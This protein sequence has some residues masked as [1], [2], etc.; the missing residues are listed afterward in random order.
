[1]TIRKPVIRKA[2]ACF[3]L[4]LTASDILLPTAAKALTSGPKQPEMTQFQ[5]AGMS[6]MVDLFSGDFKYNIPLLDVDGYPVN[7]NYAQGI[8]MDDEA[9]W[10]GLGWNLNV[11]TLN[12]QLR[13]VPDDHNGDKVE[14]VTHMKPKVTTGGSFR[15]RVEVAG[16]NMV[17]VGGSLSL[18]VFYDNYT[19]YGAEFGVGANAGLSL[20]GK[21]AGSMTMGL[22]ADINSNTTSGVS[23]TLGASL[24]YYMN[25]DNTGLSTANSLSVGYN[26]REG[27][28]DLT[29]GTSY[30]LATKDEKGR[31]SSFSHNFGSASISLNTPAFY[32]AAEIP[33]R[34]TAKTFTMDVGGAAYL[35]SV[36]VGMTGYKTVR[37]L[38]SNSQAN[39]AY[40]SMYAHNGKNNPQAL[41]DFT[42]EKDNIVVKDMN[43]IG[44]PVAMPD[45]WNYSSQAGGGQF[46]LYNGGSGVFFNNR[47]QDVSDNKTLGTDY[48]WGAYFHGGVTLFNQA[49]YDRSQK[50]VA[51]NEFSNVGDYPDPQ[52]IAEEHVYFKPVGEHTMEDAAFAGRIK[53][54]QPVSIPLAGKK[55]EPALRVPGQ[56]YAASSNIKKDGRQ[57]RNNAI[58]YL[59]AE[60]AA[61][62]G[63]D[64]KIMSYTP[65]KSGTFTPLSCFGA[66]A[67]KI[68]RVGGVRKRHHISEVSVLGGDG[69]RLVYGIPVYNNFQKEISFAIHNLPSKN[70]QVKY[71]K[72]GQAIKHKYP[73][74]NEYYFEQTQPSYASSYLLTGILSPDY[75]DVKG[76]GIT[77]DDR[78]TAVKFNYSRTT[79]KYRWRTPFGKD[80]ATLNKGLLADPD[81][82]KAS[83]VYGEKELWYLHSIE[84]KTKI[85]YFITEERKDGLGVLDIHGGVDTTLKQ[86]R[87]KE[88]RLYSKSDTSV[89]IKIVKLDY[90]YWLCQGVPNTTGAGT[91]NGK[92]MLRS[93]TFNYGSSTRG[94]RHPYTFNYKNQNEPAAGFVQLASDRWGTFKNPT[95]YNGMLNDVYPYTMNTVPDRWLLNKI[96][97]PTGGAIEVNYEE[98]TYSYVQ[99]RKAMSMQAWPTML[100]ENGTITTNLAEMRK[101]RLVKPSNLTINNLDDFR[102]HFLSGS[103]YFYGKVYTNLTD[104]PTLTDDANFDWVPC[105]A[106]VSNISVNGNNVDVEFVGKTV[107]GKNINPFAL[108]AWQRMRL[109]YPRYAYPGYKNKIPDT[110]ALDA[111]LQALSSA[112]GNFREITEDFNERALR[113]GFAATIKPEKS[114][115]RITKMDK[116]GGGARVKSLVSRE[117]WEGGPEEVSIQQYTYTTKTNDGQVVSSGV[118]SYEP[119]L[120][121][122]ENPWRQPD[123]YT[124]VNRMALNNEYYLEEPF[125][126]ALFPGPSV[127]YSEVKVENRSGR[128]VAGQVS[129][130]GYLQYEFYTSKDFPVEI[131]S[132]PLEKYERKPAKLSMMFGGNSVYEMAL[133]Q[134]YVIRIN[135]MHG[136]SKAE[137][138]FNQ[139]EKEIAATEYYYNAEERGGAMRLLNKADVVDERGYIT[140]DQVLGREL[141]LFVDAREAETSN[142]GMSVNLGVDVIPILGYPVPIPHWP[143][144]V[145]NDYR[146]FRSASV[147]KTVQYFGIPNK[148]IKKADGSSI[149]TY[150]L[151]F[152]K[153]TGAPVVTATENEFN[154][155]VYSLNIP[156]YWIYPRMGHAY[157]T[158]NMIFKDLVVDPSGV[159][160]ATFRNWMIAGDELADL[161][162]PDRRLWAVNTPLTPGGTPSVRLVNQEG[163][164]VKDIKGTFKVI[165]SGNRNLMGIM[166]GS[167]VSLQKPYNAAKLLVDPNIDL[168]SIGTLDAKAT[169]F[170]EDWGVQVEC[171]PKICP[172]GYVLS[173]DGTK[174]LLPATKNPNQSGLSLVDKSQQGFD[175]SRLTQFYDKAPN[176]NAVIGERRTYF[177]GND[178]TNNLE[179]RLVSCGVWVGNQANNQWFRIMKDFAVPREGLY[180]IGGGGDDM[181][182][183]FINGELVM[184]RSTYDESNYHVWRVKQIYLKEG[185][186]RVTLEFANTSGERMVGWE[187]YDNTVQ[188]LMDLPNEAG[189]KPNVILSTQG[190]LYDGDYQSFGIDGSGNIQT[191]LYYCPGFPQTDERIPYCVSTP[192]GECPPGYVKTADG[193]NCVLPSTINPEPKLNLIGFAGSTS[194]PAIF[195]LKGAEMRNSSGTSV[196]TNINSCFFGLPP[197]NPSGCGRLK[198]AGVWVNDDESLGGAKVGIRA[199]FT[200]EEAGTYY[201]GSGAT[202]GLEVRIDGTLVNTLSA[203]GLADENS[204]DNPMTYWHLKPVTLT[205]GKHE[206][207]I[208]GDA[209][210]YP[211]PQQGMQLMMS[212]GSIPLMGVDIYKS[213]QQEL[214]G[215]QGST[216]PQMIF[217]TSNLVMPGAVY[218][219]YIKNSAGAVTYRRYTCNGSP[220]NICEPCGIIKMARVINPYI[221]G[222]L[223]NWRPMEE[224]VYLTDRKETPRETYTP[225]VRNS[226]GYK[227]FTPFWQ[228]NGVKWLPSGNPSWVT[229]R[230]I[231]AYD[232]YSQELEN[233]NA[234]Q[235]YTGTRFGYK[236]SLPVILGSNARSRELY[237]DGFED[238]KYNSTCTPVPCKLDYFDIHRIVGTNY[239]TWLDSTRSHTGTYSLKLNTPVVLQTQAFANEHTPGI[240]IETNSNGEYQRKLDPWLGLFGFNPMPAR[241]YIVSMWV[242]DADPAK[243]TF[244]VKLKIDQDSIAGTYKATVEGWKLVEFELNMAGRN[245][246]N[247]RQIPIELRSNNST[248]RV[249]DIRIFP[250]DGQAVTYAYD[251]KTLRLMAELDA[252]NFATFYEYDDEGGLIRV[253]KETEKG[254]ITIKESRSTYYRKN[255]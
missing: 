28:K 34:N 145:N 51:D 121:G 75:V 131:E 234:L 154:D 211:P 96:E 237:Y 109:E 239:S 59:T 248:T 6:D 23:P 171:A 15:G 89:P 190:I 25:N 193:L 168:S 254:I 132:T 47:K 180:C 155:P 208:L 123:P 219:T 165:R 29:L 39:Y 46:R 5:P 205:T 222:Y 204:I 56:S 38:Q 35:V 119:A 230:W 99:N 191:S 37:E 95:P 40:G 149:T 72:L 207:D 199:C 162:R 137:R 117:I 206:I 2:L 243:K 163:K 151:L 57:S 98:D 179:R 113:K 64:K 130:T 4:C 120:G 52:G 192:V 84:T 115:V 203:S 20:T 134:G 196:G 97:L 135:D 73:G 122:D 90:E 41:M 161:N 140:Q 42:R 202:G 195:S 12:R 112:I 9:S 160:D 236:E 128:D 116:P 178:N 10:V 101:L 58:S 114:F 61:Y 87:L 241:K 24:S 27:M 238:Y 156:A 62:A 13:G 125:G 255:P 147:T 93:V 63:L 183:I 188:E 213:T 3:F 233:K 36:T 129:Q 67:A 247:M 229:A 240:Y 231:T 136:K 18:G 187:L 212:V 21:S 227:D 181:F 220:A 177:W 103:R 139:Q 172:E 218:D 78:G 197:K 158:A 245:T 17:N 224:K 246:D 107:S 141:E 65:N 110:E 100:A 49:I 186:N 201:L 83:I 53:E 143:Q 167:I 22:S 175:Y 244:D 214:L 138:V 74:T 210:P 242:N 150:N 144:S 209:T 80:S 82:D 124:Q 92:L 184:D 194:L 77:D 71:E 252:N 152:D 166:A 185:Y 33:F 76:D 216:G 91:N 170:A 182:R 221:T 189:A 106:E 148:V 55:A 226:G 102:E 44:L 253:K 1:M 69:K 251:E 50:W 142:T 176:D 86:L 111:A 19:G 159:V 133:S 153:K 105:Y 108:A 66:T 157:Q 88:I 48:S 26:T 32:P 79:D 7:L 60:E 249:D 70:N 68:G 81:D 200:V 43:H 250:Y 94:D 85:A 16:M 223:G 164:L 11:G 225:I 14:V 118:A 173:A 146:L 228:H 217:S 235:Q 198:S 54:E 45:L 30:G 104:N 174:C 8:G 215:W 127:G 232:S 31:R 169:L 126:E